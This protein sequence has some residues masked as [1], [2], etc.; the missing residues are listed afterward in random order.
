MVTVQSMEDGYNKTIKESEDISMKKMSHKL[1]LQ[2]QP[3]TE[4]DDRSSARRIRDALPAE[5]GQVNMPLAVLRKL[6]PL[7]QNARWNVTVTLAREENGWRMV[8]VEAGDTTA[9]HYGLA[10]D[11]GSTT[12]AMELVDLN[13]GKVIAVESEVNRQV[14]FGNEILS[15]IFAAHEDPEKLEQI[16][17]ATQETLQDLMEKLTEKTGI[18][19]KNASMMVISGNTTMIHFLL[20]LDAFTVFMTPYATVVTDPGFFDAGELGLNMNGMVFLVPA[21]S[22]YVGGDITSGALA[23]GLHR[24]EEVNVFLDIGTNGELLIGNRDFMVAGAG[25]AGPALEGEVIRTGMRAQP[26]AVDGVSIRN[27]EVTLSTI[28]GIAPKG[29]C[30]SGIADLL[31]ELYLEDVLDF[32]GKFNPENSS[33]MEKINGEWAYR[34]ADGLYFFQ[35]DVD[36]FLATKAAAHTMV[37]Y[38]LQKIGLPMEEISKFYLAGAFGTHIKVSSGVAIGMY[39]D[40]PQE[41]IIPAGNSSLLGAR[42]L[43]LNASLVAEARELLENITYLQFGEVANFVDIMSA[44]QGIP[45]TDL[46]RYP[47]VAKR[48]AERKRK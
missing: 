3:P 48:K 44:A 15:R 28:G 47:S 1:F 17:N 37:E 27:D 31:A 25:A 39:P 10:V 34:Y 33:R 16:R 23:L 13:A 19:T 6:Y 45:H 30:G 22:N 4:E 46:N 29:I 35:S 38:M 2:L 12:V 11:L 40:L 5:F 42:A 32:R 43:L 7:C 24:S 26:G 41:R 21:K 14:S 8:N 18:D 9:Y 36:Q 20:G